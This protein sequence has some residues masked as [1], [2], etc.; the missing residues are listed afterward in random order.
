MLEKFYI[1]IKGKNSRTGVTRSDR[2]MRYNR[3]RLRDMLDSISQFEE[4]AR[5]DKEIR[6]NLEG[7]RYGG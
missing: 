1:W 7:L 3:E 2:I 4:S 5:L 6:L